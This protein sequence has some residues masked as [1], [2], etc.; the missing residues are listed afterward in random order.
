MLHLSLK[1]GFIS[2]TRWQMRRSAQSV[3]QVVHTEPMLK[4]LILVF[5]K[6]ACTPRRHCATAC[7]H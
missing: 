2:L 4:G 7:M 5:P 3:L 6:I 1:F